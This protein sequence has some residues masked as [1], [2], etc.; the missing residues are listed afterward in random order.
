MG[1]VN[2]LNNRP[3]RVIG[4]LTAAHSFVVGIGYILKISTSSNVL[5][6]EL[7]SDQVR[8]LFG[9]LL[10]FSGFM[11]MFAFARN[12][13]KTIRAGSVLQSMVWLYATFI[14]A[15]NGGAL[16][17]LTIFLL[18]TL[19]ASYLAYAHSNRTNIIAYDRTLGAM[20]DTANEDQLH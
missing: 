14:Y 9:L 16:I 3:I 7:G 4:F 19:V 13:P 20:Q 2:A 12:N 17:A 10:I 18:P 8:I 6:A 15:F 5:Y 1:I 11:L